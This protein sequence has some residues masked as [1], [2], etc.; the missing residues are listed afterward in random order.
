MKRRITERERVMR[1][2]PEELHA[3]IEFERATRLPRWLVWV[4]LVV[5]VVGALAGLLL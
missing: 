2:T 3:E 4:C 1:M 5:A